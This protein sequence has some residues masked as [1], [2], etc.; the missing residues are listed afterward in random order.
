VD[1]TL[2][3]E[4]L[5]MTVHQLLEQVLWRKVNGAETPDDRTGSVMIGLSQPRELSLA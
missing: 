1:V 3:D 5:R 4:M 2:I